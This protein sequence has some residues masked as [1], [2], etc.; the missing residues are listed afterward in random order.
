MS[1]SSLYSMA[2]R[3]KC[4]DICACKS[5]AS[6]RDRSPIAPKSVLPFLA[7]SCSLIIVSNSLESISYEALIW[8]LYFSLILAAIFL[9]FS[10]SPFRSTTVP[11]LS[12]S[13]FILTS[14]PRWFTLC[15]FAPLY[16]IVTHW[17]CASVS[18]VSNETSSSFALPLNS[19]SMILGTTTLDFNVPPS[20][21]QF[22]RSESSPSR[23]RFARSA[24]TASIVTFVV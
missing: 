6:L 12:I 1:F 2:F 8:F 23:S 4:S 21:T 5:F 9:I 3:I 24:A 11:T 19:C 20:F 18:M 17:V 22:N 15:V 10:S 14:S 7:F 16:T 13:P